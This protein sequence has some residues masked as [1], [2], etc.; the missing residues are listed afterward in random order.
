MRIGLDA[1]GGDHA[2]GEIV[3]GALEG[4][5]AHAEVEL[6]LVGREEVVRAELARA[7]PSSCLDRLHI[8]HA[9]DV[10]AMDDSP[11]EALRQ[12]KD[13]SI[14]RLIKLA[15]EK[16]VEA[17][18]SAGNTGAFVAGCQLRLGTLKGVSR[19]GIAVVVPT[20]HGPIVLCD[21]GAN[22]S[23][24]PHHLHDYAVMACLYAKH[25]IGVAE[26]RVGLLSIGEE[27]VKGNELVKQTRALLKG[28]GS[29]R[30]V[31]NLEG[32][33]LFAGECD[34]A[35]C[36]GF[37]GN[38][39]LKLTEGL[40]DGL[41]QTITREIE[42]GIPGLAGE[43]EPVVRRIWARHDYSE[44]GGAPLLGVDGVCIICH[45][46]SEH[47]AIANAIRVASEFGRLRLNAR[48]IES[49]GP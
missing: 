38:I 5:A 27:E 18:I 20:F 28:D 12:K 29:L 7:G 37:V 31:G 19:P 30:Y 41:F 25:M 9:T 16:K 48:M 23:A 36:D 14:A 35:V 40:A 33:S 42:E 6:V 34:V 39:V 26:P 10:I 21:V 3:R 11:V 1:M 32:R 8:E 46:R 15:L 2:P 44:Y 13:S 45:G 22:I 17:I 43:F 47:R 49:L 4:L 24:K